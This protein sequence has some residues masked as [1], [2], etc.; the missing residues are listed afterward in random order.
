M[1]HRTP[2]AAPHASPSHTPPAVNVFLKLLPITLAVFIGFLTIG[3]PL[4]VLPL[5]LHDAL[6]MGTLV[7]GLVIGTQ[8]AA[9]LLSRAW[10]GHVADSQG[11]KRAVVMGLLAASASGVAY[12]A[13]LGFVASPT[14]S[15]WVL[16]LGRV[17][18]G[19]G[20]SLVVT[21]ALS[22]GVGLAGPQNAGKVMAWV[23]IAMYGA[24]AVGAPAGV[25]VNGRWGF[26]GIA[27]AAVI[28]PL[29]SLLLVA[30]VR[31]VAP[32]AARR[33]PFYKVLGQ[34]WSAGLGLALS[35]VGFGVITAFIA[36]LFAE[37][38]WGNASLAF[39]AFGLAFIGARLFFGH[40]PDKLGGARV[41]L[42]CVLVEAVG[43]LLIWGADTAAVA[44]AGAAL[45][46]FGYSLAFPGFGVEAVRRAP[47]Q[48]RGAAMG[49]YVAFLD[50]SLG[51]TGPALG[52]VAGAWGLGSVYLVGALAVA[53][54]VLV[55]LQ[56]RAPARKATHAH[57]AHH[58]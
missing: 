16:L 9:A 22:W 4:P 42:V 24:Y 45:T 17:L 8:F 37:R 44:Y 43:Q 27:V 18:L 54:S 40:L 15:V 21:G 26:T 33:T 13:S 46:G 38:G 29:V 23:G 10:A 51:L 49:A 34:V 36:L 20:E 3:L 41:A 47:P 55:A 12:L 56:L 25:A 5:H 2:A 58:G 50:I 19:C 57:G 14:A 35:S 53:S 28:L 1:P 7:V 31:A 11:A 32:T 6:G 30:S 52:A 39:T 48:S